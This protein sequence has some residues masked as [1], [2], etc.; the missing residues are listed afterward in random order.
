MAMGVVK[1]YPKTL[2]GFLVILTICLSIGCKVA[3]TKSGIYE[4][5]EPLEK[6]PED[7]YSIG[8]FSFERLLLQEDS[9][10]SYTWFKDE[11][12]YSSLTTMSGKWTI[13]DDSILINPFLATDTIEYKTVY[14]SDNSRK[15]TIELFDQFGGKYILPA[16]GYFK[17]DRKNFKI[18][19]GVYKEVLPKRYKE[20]VIWDYT[21]IGRN[22]IPIKRDSMYIQ[23]YGLY[24][25][26]TRSIQQIRLA[27]NETSLDGNM[28]VVGAYGDAYWA[29]SYFLQEKLN[30]RKWEKEEIKTD[31]AVKNR[32]LQ[33]E[34]E[35]RKQ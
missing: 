2:S 18:E 15:L 16:V 23:V 11:S 19:F 7:L 9:M 32:F 6:E 29:K 5:F 25:T 30:Y 34:L 27:K 28:Y 14:K 1:C 24:A 10:F 26:G 3:N 22:F 21:G 35:R 13:A 4:H 20:V 33:N 12:C 8:G 31:M 17:E